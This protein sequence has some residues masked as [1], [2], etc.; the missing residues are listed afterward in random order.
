MRTKLQRIKQIVLEYSVLPT[1]F[2]EFYRFG[3]LKEA[4]FEVIHEEE[5]LE[6]GV[7]DANEYV[8]TSRGW[9]GCSSRHNTKDAD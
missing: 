8:N 5:I 2:E 9:E 4:I 1:T 6:D 3:K 7:R